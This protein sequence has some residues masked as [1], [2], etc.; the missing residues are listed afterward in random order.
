MLRI[1]C[2]MA[3]A[4]ILALQSPLSHAAE[5]DNQPAPTLNA[6]AQV[7]EVSRVAAST[8]PGDGDQLAR[9]QSTARQEQG[10]AAAASAPLK[11]EYPALALLAMA[12]ISMA[13]LSRRDSLR[14]DR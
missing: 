6:S 14:I 12:I 7:G 4:A 5:T 11:V 8:I 3:V 10:H 1:K 13:A 2:A 9:A